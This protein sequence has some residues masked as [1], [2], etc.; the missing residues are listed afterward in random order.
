MKTEEEM[1]REEALEWKEQATTAGLGGLSVSEAV[2]GAMFSPLFQKMPD[3]LD[4]V[5][6]EIVEIHLTVHLM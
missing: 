1:E 5:S 3:P 2:K 6:N 4:A